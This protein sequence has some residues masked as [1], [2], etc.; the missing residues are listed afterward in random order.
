MSGSGRRVH[1]ARF[2]RFGYGCGVQVAGFRL[3]VRVQTIKFKLPSSGRWVMVV[4]FRSLGSGCLSGSG[5][6]DP[7][8]VFCKARQHY[9]G[10]SSDVFNKP[11]VTKALSSE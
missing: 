6:T 7:G 8:V 4:R 10:S 11:F 1:A 9:F 3:S 5:L 2:R